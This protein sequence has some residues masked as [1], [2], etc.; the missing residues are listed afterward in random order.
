MEPHTA[1]TMQATQRNSNQRLRMQVSLPLISRKYFE[2][3]LSTVLVAR[4]NGGG[5][6][7]SRT[8][9]EGDVTRQ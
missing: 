5:V 7:Q 1:S 4:T 8:L 9:L 6:F 2:C 3:I